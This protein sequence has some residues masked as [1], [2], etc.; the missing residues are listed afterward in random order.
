LME[1]DKETHDL[2]LEQAPAERIKEVAEKNGF[3]D[4]TMDG[5][6]KVLKGVTTFEEVMRTT[7][8]V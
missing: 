4:M 1:L 7:R 3:R 5:V 8:S 6:E 2:V